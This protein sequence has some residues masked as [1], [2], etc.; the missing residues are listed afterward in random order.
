MVLDF[1]INGNSILII[2]RLHALRK[3]AHVICRAFF[4][5]F[6]SVVKIENFIGRSLIL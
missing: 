3:L 2:S 5:F 1:A 4:F 6:F